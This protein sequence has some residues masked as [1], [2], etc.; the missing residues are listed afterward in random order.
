MLDKLA[1]LPKQRLEFLDALGFSSHYRS[2]LPIRESDEV[3]RSVVSLLAVQV[4][5]D[6]AVRQD[7]VVGL[8]PN[9]DVLLNVPAR[10]CP[11]M[12]RGVDG[13]VSLIVG[14]SPAFPE[15]G[16]FTPVLPK[17]CALL[18]VLPVIDGCAPTAASRSPITESLA[19]KALVRFRL[20]S[21]RHNVSIACNQ[22]GVKR[23]Q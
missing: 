15:G 12:V 6:P 9:N 17:L 13:D 23:L 5:N 11:R 21:Y 8:L 7:C 2:V 18:G 20:G 10:G 3:D 22:S 19:V 16:V 4:V 14:G 1:L